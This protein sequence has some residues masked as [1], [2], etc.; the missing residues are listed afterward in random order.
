MNAAGSYAFD[1]DLPS[2]PPIF[3]VAPHATHLIYQL[4]GT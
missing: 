3:V 1:H 2:C 4:K